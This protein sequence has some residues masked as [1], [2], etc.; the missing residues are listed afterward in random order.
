VRPYTILIICENSL[1]SIVI[2]W[3]FLSQW[4]Y[5]STKYSHVKTN[6]VHTL[7][8]VKA[9]GS[10]LLE[11]FKDLLPEEEFRKCTNNPHLGNAWFKLTSKVIILYLFRVIFIL[12]H[13]FHSLLPFIF[14]SLKGSSNVFSCASTLILVPLSSLTARDCR[15]LR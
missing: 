7:H 10:M 1:L 6:L 15:G 9:V 14:P 3:S 2:V 12:Q 4:L 8:R 11:S 5:R 13:S